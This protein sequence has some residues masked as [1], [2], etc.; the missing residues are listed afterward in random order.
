MATA[1]DYADSFISRAITAVRD[2]VDDPTVNA[3]WTDAKIIRQLELSYMVVVS[4]KNRT[5]LTPAVAKHVVTISSST[6]TYALPYTM[7]TVEAIYEGDGYGGKIFYRARGNYNP[8]G[9]RLWIEDNTLHMQTTGTISTGTEITVEY[10]PSGVS[11]LHHGACTINSDGDEITFGATPNEG[12]LDT[13]VNA[14]LGDTFRFFNV[15]G[16]VVTNNYMQERKI[17]AWAHATRVAT[18]SPALTAIPTT[19]DGEILYEIAPNIHKGLDLIVPVHTAWFIASIEGATSRA[20]HI[21]NT[22]KDLL[23]T[24]RLNAY[25]S[26]IQDAHIGKSDSFQNRKY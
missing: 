25:Y 10:T 18:I 4:E 6:L 11:R 2:Y 8:F 14:Y 19:D 15:I 1:T 7:G 23:R 21:Q 13:H 12:T 16:S 3:K 22:Y 26:N 24:L 17:T 20:R 9:R 5:S